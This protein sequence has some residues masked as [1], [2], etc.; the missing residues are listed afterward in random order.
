MDFISPNMMMRLS[1]AVLVSFA[2]LLVAVPWVS[3]AYSFNFTSSA[4]QANV[5][6]AINFK[7]SVQGLNTISVYLFVTGPGLDPNGATL[8]NIRVSSGGGMF[9][10]VPVKL[11]DNTWQYT[12]DTAPFADVMQPGYYT[13]Y[14][15]AAPMGLGRLSMSGEP[16]ASKTILFLKT[17][18]SN[19]TTE[20]PLYPVVAIAAVTLTMLGSATLARRNRT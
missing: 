14:V 3:A 10:T 12:W 18:Q 8:E 7:G 11:V 5:G 17:A 6:D 4:D 16:F 2:F 19:T 1:L 15:V 20:S 13:V 9:T